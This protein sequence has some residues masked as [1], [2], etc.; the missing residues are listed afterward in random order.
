MLGRSDWRRPVIRAITR[1]RIVN[2]DARRFFARCIVSRGEDGRYYADLTGPQGSG[3]LTSMSHANALT[4]IP[5]DQAAAEAGAEIDVMMLDW[6]H[7][8]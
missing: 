2:V 7:A 1:E 3:I 8:G 4:I 5:E 6:E